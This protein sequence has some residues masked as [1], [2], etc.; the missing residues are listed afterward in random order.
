MSF[1]LATVALLAA[2]QSSTATPESAPSP[3]A[4]AETAFVSV[5]VVPADRER[6]L[7]NQTV[8]VRAGRIAAVGPADR[9]EIPAR[10]TRVEGRGKFLMPGIAE[11]HGHLPDGNSTEDIPRLWFKLFLANGVTTVRGVWGAP[12]Q[13]GLRDRINRGELLGPQLFLFGTPMDGKNTPTPE[14]AREKVREYKRAGYDGL[15]ISE[16]LSL[17]TYQALARTAKQLNMPFGGHVPNPVGLQRALAAGQRNIEHLDGYVEALV[18]KGVPAAGR[19]QT[20]VMLAGIMRG[21]SPGLDHLDESQIPGL[22]AAT[23]KA[24]T[25]ITPTMFVWRTLFG[26]AD[27]TALARLPELQYMP[28]RMVDSWARQ[29][30]AWAEEAAPVERLRKLM[31]V[32]DRLLKAMADAGGLLMLGADSPQQYTVPGFSLRHETAALVK[33]GMTPWQVV[34][35][36]TIAPARYLGRDKDF[37]TVAV[38]KRADLILADGNPLEDVANIFRSSGGYFSH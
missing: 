35:A 14:R 22:V 15:K 1:T 19:P 20:D 2:A 38:G 36:A 16:G 6:L 13:F 4:Q 17:A 33:A 37:G 18:R 7:P 26:D 3:P 24:R 21:D 25:M 8:L 23:K 34:E 10:A 5:T 31:N 12:N 9:V 27:A 29:Q 30:A 28:P 11:M 32:R